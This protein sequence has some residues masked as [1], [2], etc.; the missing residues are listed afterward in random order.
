MRFHARLRLNSFDGLMASDY[1]FAL[2]SEIAQ[3]FGAR[4]DSIQEKFQFK[5]VAFLFICLTFLRRDIEQ[6]SLP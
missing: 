3:L 4:S 2:L 6:Q 5:F 1:T